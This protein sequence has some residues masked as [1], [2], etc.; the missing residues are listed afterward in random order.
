MSYSAISKQI[1]A[2]AMVAA[3][4]LS[5]CTKDESHP[6]GL[7][8]IPEDLSF[9]EKAFP[10]VSAQDRAV[11]LRDL[12]LLK[13]IRAIDE[14]ILP[15]QTESG[16][17]RT[18]RAGRLS[19]ASGPV[20]LSV[21][22]LLAECATDP[23][24][25]EMLLDAPQPGQSESVTLT[26]STSG[27]K[28][29]AVLS[30]HKTARIRLIE[31]NTTARRLVVYGTA[32]LQA[33]SSY[34]DARQ[35]KDIGIISST[36]LSHCKIRVEQNQGIGASYEESRVNGQFSFAD[37]RLGKAEYEFSVRALHIDSS[38]D[39]TVI[40]AK[41]KMNGKTYPLNFL[42]DNRNLNGRSSD[43]IY[44]GRQL[45]TSEERKA[46]EIFNFTKPSKD[47]IFKQNYFAKVAR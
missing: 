15:P 33:Q 28:C 14:Q 38:K 27:A 44:L 39:I 4:V 26:N 37:S 18:D 24:K 16:E 12:Q 2:L 46:L 41:L 6:K 47:E 30:S 5:A 19:K 9:N 40:R 35:Q 22:S 42:S 43:E 1:L 29:T 23:K 8:A 17:E 11:F 45:L 25:I 31:N 7:N 21:K 13:N 20:Q 10:E 3:F 32:T 36:R 34:L